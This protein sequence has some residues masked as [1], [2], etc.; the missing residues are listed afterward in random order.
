M[1]A[2]MTR[3]YVVC[4][5][6]MTMQYVC[7]EAL[8][9]FEGDLLSATTD[10]W[11]HMLVGMLSH[12]TDKAHVAE[13]CVAAR[14]H[15][16]GGQH[17]RLRRLEAELVGGD[18]F[19]ETLAHD[20]FA[21]VSAYGVTRLTKAAVAKK[22]A[23]AGSNRLQAIA[24]ET[25]RVKTASGSVGARPP[26]RE[27]PAA[28]QPLCDAGMVEEHLHDIIKGLDAQLAEDGVCEEPE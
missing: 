2:A 5:E 4:V 13:V 12:R 16:F 6:G 20:A 17:V 22:A 14:L 18:R 28:W 26:P 15:L 27:G 7:T 23:P 1:C 9:H 10:S 3:A 25:K 21:P 19:K 8:D 11:Q 24:P